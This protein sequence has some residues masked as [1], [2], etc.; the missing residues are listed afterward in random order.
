MPVSLLELMIHNCG[1]AATV[2][3]AVKPS[4]PRQL[5]FC[6]GPPPLLTHRDFDTAE[7]CLSKGRSRLAPRHQSRRKSAVE[8]GAA[9][10]DDHGAALSK[11][12]LVLF[13]LFSASG[14]KT[15][16]PSGGTFNFGIS[17]VDAAP[18]PS[19][20][21]SPAVAFSRL[22]SADA[23]LIAALANAQMPT[24]MGAYYLYSCCLKAI[25]PLNP[26]G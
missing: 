6:G 22:E 10:C 24:A 18:L 9:V 26:P 7:Q 17:V 15:L 25:A 11:A 23:G 20:F 12:N 1:L 3:S 2:T 4:F 19:G 8:H 13:T 21:G 5:R 16:R 14:R